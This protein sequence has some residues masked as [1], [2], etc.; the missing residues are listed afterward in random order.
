[1]PGPPRAGGALRAASEIKPGG[2]F[3]AGE[4]GYAERTGDPSLRV[5]WLSLGLGIGHP[6]GLRL[7]SLTVD[8]RL[9]LVVERVSFTAVER[10]DSDSDASWKPG[11]SAAIDAHWQALPPVGLVVSAVTFVDPRRTVVKTGGAQVGE[12]P[13]LG[14]S[15]FLGLRLKLR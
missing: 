7:R 3:G 5:R 10:G 12:T 8:A 1:V 2:F 11:A 13:A 14:L 4:L 6:L 9:L 15:G